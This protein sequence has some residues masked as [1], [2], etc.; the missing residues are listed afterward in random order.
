MID[1]RWELIDMLGRG[2]VG[3]VWRA[4]PVRG[5]DDLAIKALREEFSEHA[6]LRR[7]FAREARAASSLSHPNIAGIHAFKSD[8]EGR[9]YIVM[10][11]IEGPPLSDAIRTGL[12]PRSLLE[13]ADQLLA[14]LAHAHAR[15]VIHRDL[16]PDNVLLADATLPE[17]LGTPKL[18]DFGIATVA[19]EGEDRETMQGEVVGTP[20]YM[21][22]EQALGERNLGPRTDLYNV[23][24]VLYELAT[25]SP[26][27]GSDRGLAVMSRHAN[28][29]I[30]EPVPRPGFAFPDGFVA[31]LMKSLSKNPFDRYA[32][33]GEMRA[34]IRPILDAARN[35]PNALELPLPLVSEGSADT[36]ITAPELPSDL[37]RTAPLEIEQMPADPSES[38]KT[39][40][41]PAPVFAPW[42]FRVPFVGRTDERELL[43]GLAERAAHDGEGRIVLL[44]GEAGVGKTRLTNWLKEVVEESGIM[45]AN[46]GAFTREGSSS[47][48]GAQEVLE[49]VFRTRGL[50]R[51]KA[52]QKIARR[53]EEWEYESKHDLDA[54]ID[55]IRPTR[56]DDTRP[57]NVS[58]AALF[59]TITR[60]LEAGA[61]RK[62]RLIVL[63]DIHWAGRELVE[64]LDDLAVEMRRRALPILIIATYRTEE[65]AER[66]ELESKLSG[67]S[68]YV[69]EAVEK[70]ELERLTHD[71]GRE[72]IDALL[73]CDDAL[74][75]MILERTS[76]N[77]LH[78]L[79]LVRY[80][81]QEGLLEWD[82]E[83]WR[84]LNP[85]DVAGAVPPSLGDLFRVRIEQAEA[86][87]G[88]EGRLAKLLEF[89]AVAG[90]RFHW[91][92]LQQMAIESEPSL[93]T[94]FDIDLDRLISE[95]FLSEADQRGDWYGFSHG[96]LRDY[97]L[98]R[99]GPSRAR[100]L[101]RIAANAKMKTHARNLDPFALEI[102]EHLRGAR[103]VHEALDW[104]LRAAR[105]ALRAA[106]LRQSTTAYSAALDI[107]DELLGVEQTTL[108]PLGPD[109]ERATFDAADVEVKAYL[110]TLTRLGDLH[111]GFGE[112]GTAEVYYRRVVRLVGREPVR[113]P[114][115]VAEPLGYAWLGLGH[116]A[117]Q[118]GDFEAAEWAFRKVRE[119]VK[120]HEAPP[121]LDEHA[122]RGLARVAWHRG[123]YPHAETLA[124]DAFESASQGGFVEGQAESLWILGEIS[125]MQGFVEDAREHYARSLDLYTT[126]NYVSG[127]ARNLLSLAQAARYQKDFVASRDLYDRAL[128]H[129]RNLGDRRGMGQCFNGLGDICRFE[130][131]P[132][133]AEESYRRALELYDSIG[134]EYDVAVAL[135][136]L[137]LNALGTSEYDAAE[138]YLVNALALVEAGDFPYLIAGIEY[139]L[140][141]VKALSGAEAE[142]EEASTKALDISERIGIA[143]IDYAQPLEKLGQ[144]RAQAGRNDEARELWMKAGEIY[145][146]L[147]LDADAERVRGF[148]ETT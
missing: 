98:H 86:S 18:V 36:P 135:A 49:S 148:A 46:V 59:A 116:V 82:G 109:L 130:R 137:G 103:E 23:G 52:A 88:S 108:E 126:K 16:K 146:E 4:R 117:W 13:L 102:A 11:L 147:G 61:R 22:P 105:S 26:P 121:R 94:S 25:G 28:E 106:M 33:A 104:Y 56:D 42:N 111:E 140:A 37:R 1:G 30:P 41:E 24:L 85:E 6:T 78:L 45:R 65:L 35:D 123:E 21:S 43:R 132:W 99:V 141:L 40:P 76:G 131:K 57:A 53:L 84:S 10:E 142:S 64:F 44:G 60:V 29:P 68:R 97:L 8:S 32:S 34:A 133:E 118:R 3:E 72:L 48:R 110:D 12:S 19:F 90:P 9:L 58:T 75:D 62:P 55:F 125:R 15:G 114:R 119:L 69:G 107:M 20:R 139:N 77:P 71:V 95:G 31:V 67:L 50:P 79:L 124:R 7:R 112:F 70:L 120:R 80:L 89:A 17:S 74:A 14:G 2:G 39:A 122:A 93:A 136:N 134:A 145:A 101:N 127:I 129:Y 51:Q 96:L 27:F 5:G 73:P 113:L 63:D 115:D 81:R 47:L 143:D 144:L 87:T 83:M 128:N 100:R 54:L 138:D 91:E 92:I 38:P 66:P